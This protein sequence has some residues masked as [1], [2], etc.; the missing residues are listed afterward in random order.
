MSRPSRSRCPA[1]PPHRWYGGR[2]QDRVD[3]RPL[4]SPSVRASGKP[5]MTHLRRMFVLVIAAL[6]ASIGAAP[7]LAQA[8]YPDRPVRVILPFPPG[9][10]VDVIGR[11]LAQQ[12]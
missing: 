12:L 5:I 7:V 6:V 1:R 2:G 4:R 3:P 8:K 10:L 9:G 11:V